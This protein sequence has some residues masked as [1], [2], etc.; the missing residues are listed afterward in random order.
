MD[1]TGVRIKVMQVAAKPAQYTQP[2]DPSVWTQVGHA[3]IPTLDHLAA[4]RLPRSEFSHQEAIQI[5]QDFLTADSAPA[6]GVVRFPKRLQ[7]RRQ[8]TA[9]E[10]R[11]HKT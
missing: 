7:P 9:E 11:G 8:R 3:V 6:A 4:D 1:E 10:T 2:I 5:K